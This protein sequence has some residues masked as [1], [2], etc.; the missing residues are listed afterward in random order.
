MDAIELL[1]E[2]HADPN[3]QD[4][5]GGTSLHL[6]I[7]NKSLDAI[8]LLLENHADLTMLNNRGRKP[9]VVAINVFPNAIPS[10]LV[11]GG[12]VITEDDF[13]AIHPN[14][15]ILHYSA[16]YGSAESF[17]IVRSLLTQSVF[18]S[19]IND[20]SSVLQGVPLQIAV[21]RKAYRIASLL[22]ANGAKFHV[23]DHSGKILFNFRKEISCRHHKAR[24]MKSYLRDHSELLRKDLGYCMNFLLAFRHFVGRRE[25]LKFFAK[26]QET[27]AVLQEYQ[28]HYNFFRLVMFRRRFFTVGPAGA[29]R[30]LLKSVNARIARIKLL[31]RATQEGHDAKFPL[32]GKLLMG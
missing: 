28:K 26:K 4:S 29:H 19:R 9:I 32:L 25:G 8:K 1:L 31:E 5:S 3:F 16:H 10:L 17:D 2:N 11:S 18:H 21:R 13:N 30:H 27:Q 6:A 24:I 15:F 14:R 12:D 23:K 22:I 20:Y 7:K